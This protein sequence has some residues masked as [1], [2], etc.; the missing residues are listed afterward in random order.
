MAQVAL[1]G[2][3]GAGSV[4]SGYFSRLKQQTGITPPIQR[5]GTRT[6]LEGSVT[7]LSI[8]E[9]HAS[10][11]LVEEID[12]LVTRRAPSEPPLDAGSERQGDSL[13]HASEDAPGASPGPFARPAADTDDDPA[14]RAAERSDR[15]IDPQ[16]REVVIYEESL[17][18]TAG[19][20]AAPTI[21]PRSID[22][23]SR[24]ERE[25]GLDTETDASGRANLAAASTPPAPIE[26]EITESVPSAPQPATQADLPDSMKAPA[27][28]RAELLRAVQEWVA[29]PPSEVAVDERPVQAD[30]G[31]RASDP[32][33]RGTR[34]ERAV[35]QGLI[36]ADD[37][38]P[39]AAIP[40]F[41]LSIGS[42]RVIVED[43]SPSLPA[44]VTAPNSQGP[45]GAVGSDKGDY[46]RFRRHYLRR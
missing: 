19:A 39:V 42:I 14:E 32:E 35:A 44:P 6:A 43:P 46:L 27:Q 12:E 40:E 5:G 21:P 17:T 13:T 16:D 38:Q 2:T 20:A 26:V 10:A 7:E 36:E 45:A 34:P 9:P 3:P 11:P 29:A 25:S 18:R 8:G 22:A 15:S 37:R 33:V 24:G 41:T 23:G 1:P 31:W 4:V 30:W 28:T